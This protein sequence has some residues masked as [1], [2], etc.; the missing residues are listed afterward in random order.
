VLQR[1]AQTPLLT[2]QQVRDIVFAL[3]NWEETLEEH[4]T[5]KMKMEKVI[6]PRCLAYK[7]TTSAWEVWMD[8]AT[9][10]VFEV[11]PLIIWN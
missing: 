5:Q 8:A 6:T 7:V 4:R 2:E 9:G 11:L 10:E 3:P 1:V